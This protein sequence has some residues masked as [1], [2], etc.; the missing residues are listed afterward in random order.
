MAHET[1]D[2]VAVRN[3]AD[4]RQVRHAG[5]HEQ[6]RRVQQLA[7]L[8]AVLDTPFGRRFVWRL[9]EE[10]RVFQSVW[11]PSSRIHYLAGRQDFGHFLMSEI[12]QADGDALFVLMR[13]AR[14]QRDR[15]AIDAEAARTPRADERKEASDGSR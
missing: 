8:C 14:A 6:R 9:L 15:D 5:R 13:E 11:D 3:A 2:R 4:P 12:D 1:A 10:C 7:D